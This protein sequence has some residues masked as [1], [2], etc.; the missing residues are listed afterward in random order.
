MAITMVLVRTIGLAARATRL[1]DAS[2]VPI[3]QPL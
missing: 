2:P 1:P 3:A